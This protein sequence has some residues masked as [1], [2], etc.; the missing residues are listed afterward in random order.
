[1]ADDLSQTTL[2]RLIEAGQLARHTLLRPLAGLGLE[3]GDDAIILAMPKSGALS[4]KMLC[5][6]TGLDRNGLKV[7]IRRLVN[8]GMVSRMAIEGELSPLIVLSQKGIEARKK[9]CAHWRELEDALIGELKPKQQRKLEAIMARLMLLIPS[10]SYRTAD[11]LA[12]AGPVGVDLVVATDSAQA[13]AAGAE[14][15]IIRVDFRDIARGTAQI[16]DHAGAHPLDAI[17]A[18]DGE[19]AELAAAAGRALGLQPARWWVGGGG[20]GEGGGGGWGGYVGGAGRGGR[21]G[22]GR[23]GGKGRDVS[24]RGADEKRGGGGR[25]ATWGWCRACEA[26]GQAGERESVAAGGGGRDGGMG[27]HAEQIFSKTA[28]P[29]A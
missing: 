26:D 2:Y 15:R 25:E 13:L 21:G 18:V 19:G 17:L 24:R 10:S 20:G 9:L 3:A 27:I 14:G 28:E 4:I 22:W 12:A 16:V 1:M 8:L 6:A 23:R 29:K 5:A 11:F 7:R